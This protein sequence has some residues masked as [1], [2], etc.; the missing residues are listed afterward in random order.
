VLSRGQR[1]GSENRSPAAVIEQGA[2][3]ANT[4]VAKTIEWK[5]ASASLRELAAKFEVLLT[6]ALPD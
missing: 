5:F 4:H 2:F 3:D 6:L 1:Q